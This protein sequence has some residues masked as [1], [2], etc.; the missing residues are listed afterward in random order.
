MSSFVPLIHNIRTES[1]LHLIAICFS[2]LGHAFAKQHFLIY[3]KKPT[4]FFAKDVL[5]MRFHTDTP[6]IDRNVWDQFMA[7]KNSGFRDTT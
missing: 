1:L 7:L 6:R 3:L 5:F 2:S 4:I